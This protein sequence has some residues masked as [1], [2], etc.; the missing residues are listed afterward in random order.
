MKYDLV[1]RQARVFDGHGHLNGTFDLGIRSSLIE[2]VSPQPLEGVM[3][4]DGRGRTVLPGLID[5][6]IH[7][8]D[9][10]ATRSEEE[11]EAFFA[12]GLRS[13]LMDFLSHGVTTVK[14]VGDPLPDSLRARKLLQT[15]ELAGP[16]LKVAGLGITAPGGHPGVTIY[17]NNDW[18]R[19]RSVAEV[20]DPGAARAVVQRLASDGVDAIK[21]LYQG[22]CDC[23]G[24]PYYWHPRYTK[25]MAIQIIRLRRPVLT[26]VIDE[27]HRQGL[28]VTAHTIE[29]E[30]AMAALEDGIDALEHGVVDEP[31]E[32]SGVIERLLRQGSSYVPTLFV[33]ANEY[34]MANVLKVHQAG[35]R[36]VVGTDSYSGAGAY[37]AN[38]LVELRRL[39]E[40]GL[41]N[42]AVLKAAT[43]EAARHLRDDS[44]GVV[45]AGKAADLILVEG[46]PVADLACVEKMAAVIKDGRVV[47]LR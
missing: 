24:T 12:D 42:T 37:G 7:L 29:A 9:F 21:V 5:T 20:D 30:A 32:Q 10:I 6:H 3:V 41:S 23:N 4:I 17:R 13:R 18:Y 11:M 43:S 40:A 27:S 31:I 47:P 35:V 44:I 22:G 1:I 26:A 46:D 28:M 39:A 25:G 34:S 19:A 45:A 15:R 2:A 33:K 8:F 14:S 38:T 16:N 36:V